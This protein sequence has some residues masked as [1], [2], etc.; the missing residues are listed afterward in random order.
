MWELYIGIINIQK[1]IPLLFVPLHSSIRIVICGERKGLTITDGDVF[2]QDNSDK[3]NDV[4]LFLDNEERCFMKNKI[5]NDSLLV[6]LVRA[7]YLL[8][9]IYLFY[10]IYDRRVHYIDLPRKLMFPTT[11]TQSV[12]LIFTSFIHDDDMEPHFY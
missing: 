2:F 1:N 12:H 6:D 3:K 5:K 4:L 11:H 9:T 7:I 10:E 8:C